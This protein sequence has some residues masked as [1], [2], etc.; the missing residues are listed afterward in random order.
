M[1]L[2]N[3]FCVSGIAA[4]AIGGGFWGAGVSPAWGIEASAGMEV[5]TRGP[6]HEAFAETVAFDPAAG[7]IVSQQPPTLIEEVMP[8][9]RPAGD[10][11]AWIPGYWG[12]DEDQNDFLWISGIWRNLPPGREWVPGYCPQWT[13]AI[14]GL[15]AIGRMQKRLKFPISQNRRAAW[16]GDLTSPH[17]RTT[18][19][20]YQEAGST[21]KTA[22]R[23]VL[24][25]G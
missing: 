4:I 9:Q 21:G 15:P 16:S 8:D 20:G 24:A 17:P 6:V 5:M 22:M 12:W 18:K 10:N 2:K 1:N 19:H 11:V 25:T 14:N 23:G 3:Y 13:P 7:I